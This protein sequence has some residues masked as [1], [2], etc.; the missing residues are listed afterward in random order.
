MSHGSLVDSLE[1]ASR[2]LP[3]VS[4]PTD[5]PAVLA[6]TRTPVYLRK[7]TLRA[8]GTP[9]SNTPDRRGRTLNRLATVQ[10]WLA[11]IELGAY[12]LM[13]LVSLVVCGFVVWLLIS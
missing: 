9:L 6:V 8:F 5:L 11:S 7:R 12:L 10:L 3:W 4:H 1:R 13:L 2:Q